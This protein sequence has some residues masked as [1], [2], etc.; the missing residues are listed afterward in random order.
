MTWMS[1]SLRMA[2][3]IVIES[4]SLSLKLR[5]KNKSLGVI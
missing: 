3:M 1:G 2:A 5:N 4:L